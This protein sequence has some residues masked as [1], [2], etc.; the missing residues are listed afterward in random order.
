[1]MKK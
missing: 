1:L